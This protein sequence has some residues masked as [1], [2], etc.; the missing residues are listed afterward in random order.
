MIEAIKSAQQQSG[1]TANDV[2]KM[3]VVTH[4][5]WLKVCDIKQPRTGLEAK[6]SY[7]HLAAMIINHIDTSADKAFTDSL[8]ADGS[9]Q[10]LSKKIDIETDESLNDT[11]A[12][13][14][15]SLSSGAPIQV[16][17]DLSEPIADDVLERGLRAKATGLLGDKA[18]ET[19]WSV[20][21][22]IESASARDIGKLLAQ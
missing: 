7:V 21:Q 5:R 4:P 8:A 3:T 13:L 6:F 2:E 1:F 14:K 18:A 22:D 10:S 17:H 9:L 11:T 15:I 16:S 12:H 19:I 20:V